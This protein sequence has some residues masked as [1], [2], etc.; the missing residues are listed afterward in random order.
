MLDRL[1]YE[2]APLSEVLAESS[3]RIA[4]VTFDDGLASVDLTVRDL[5]ARGV[6]STVFVCP[7]RVG[8][9]NDWASVGSIREPLLDIDE[10]KS[11]RD[12]GASFGVHGWDHQA[13]IGRSDREVDDDLA[14]CRD[15]FAEQLR[16]RADIFAWPFG[17]FDPTAVE[18]V[19]QEYRYALTVEPEW[20][21]EVRNTAIP[22]VVGDDRTTFERFADELEL[23]AFL[24]ADQARPLD[25]PGGDRLQ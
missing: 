21:D 6:A 22:R 25:F 4:A 13:F 17:R 2:P 18:R 20:S 10:L 5:L 19:A 7:G 11:L 3:R 8:R 16:L 14:R 12:L 15:W 1:G 9:V 24:L 23:K